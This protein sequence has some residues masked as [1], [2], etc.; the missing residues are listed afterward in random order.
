MVKCRVLDLG[1]VNYEKAYYLQKKLHEFRREGRIDDV[2][3]LLEHEPVVTMGRGGK[4]DNILVSEELLQSKGI[5]VFEIDRGGDVTLHCPGQ[6]VGYPIFDLRIHGKNIHRY[7]R[8]IEEVIIRSLKVYGIEGQRIENHTGVW[9]GGRKIASIGIGVK[10]WVT[11]HGFSL[12]INP[13]LSYFSLI[14]PCGFE[15]RTVTS[16][17]EILGRSVE[18]GD[19]RQQ[20]IEKFAEVF[21]LEIEENGKQVS[22]LDSKE[23]VSCSL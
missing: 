21:A 12:N 4:R 8:N 19:F 13:D 22:T 17:S 16:M 20:L 10:G 18:P 11:F 9:V 3:I 1:L 7:L 6:L 15:S 2:L 5:R 14:R 23:I